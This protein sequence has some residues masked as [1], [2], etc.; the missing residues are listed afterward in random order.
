ML[1]EMIFSFLNISQNKNKK[2][3]KIQ[4]TVIFGHIRG[5]KNDNIQTSL[6][7]VQHQVMDWNK[8]AHNKI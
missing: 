5:K 2:H 3:P 8:Q 1:G 4:I 6:K 7:D